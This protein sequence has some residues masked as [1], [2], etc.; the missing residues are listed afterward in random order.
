[1]VDQLYQKRQTL[2][3]VF[4]EEIIE[5]E[6]VAEKQVEEREVVQSLASYAR[7]NYAGTLNQ[8]LA[9]LDSVFEQIDRED[10]QLKAREKAISKVEAKLESL[11]RLKKHNETVFRQQN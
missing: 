3:K 6:T 4:N 1:M 11:D 9:E 10:A 5:Q 7:Q 8:I 2:L